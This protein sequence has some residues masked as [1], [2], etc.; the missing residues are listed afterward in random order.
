[1]GEVVGSCVCL[2]SQ[3]QLSNYFLLQDYFESNIGYG[4]GSSEPTFYFNYAIYASSQ[5]IILVLT[6]CFELDYRFDDVLDLNKNAFASH[7]VTYFK[8]NFSHFFQLL[9]QT[10][11][12]CPFF[13]FKALLNRLGLLSHNVSVFKQHFLLY[14]YHSFWIGIVWIVF[15]THFE[16]DA[17]L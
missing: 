11:I 1:M 2:K 4:S 8:L 14:S 7:H 13:T 16:P 5:F 6:E 17:S 10:Q 12:I 9:L 3:L 15:K